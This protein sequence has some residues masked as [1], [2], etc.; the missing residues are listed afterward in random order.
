M[1]QEVDWNAVLA[2]DWQ[3]DTRFVYGVRS[4]GIYC[5]PTCPSRRPRRDQVLFFERPESAEQA[6]FR[7]CRRCRP[8]IRGADPRAALVQGVCRFIEEH[9][10]ERLS[11]DALSRNAGF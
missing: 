9:S 1:D 3:F 7:P 5:R 6:G 10:E 4:T 11:L 2:R 8:R